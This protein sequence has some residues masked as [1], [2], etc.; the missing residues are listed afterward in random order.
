MPA[1]S[2]RQDRV[3]QRGAFLSGLA[4][5]AL[6]LAGLIKGLSPETSADTLNGWLTT[7]LT[8]AWIA[9]V[10]GL[11]VRGRGRTLGLVVPALVYLLLIL[12]PV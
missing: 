10:C 4:G 7:S 2:P 1:L 11:M 3:L 5:L 12:M 9:L 8:G 6:M